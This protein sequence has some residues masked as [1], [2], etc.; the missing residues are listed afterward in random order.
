MAN[1]NLRL[2][3]DAAKLLESLLGELVFVGGCATALL[4]TDQAAADVRPT[5]D[6]DA[7]AEIT[8]YPEYTEFSKSSEELDFKKIPAKVRHCAAG[9]KKPRLSMS[10]RSTRG[11]SDLRIRGIG[12][13]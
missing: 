1:P 5:L 3:T 8:S 7:I 10:C 9:G 6:V 12:R 13:Q 11:F 4:I 2:L